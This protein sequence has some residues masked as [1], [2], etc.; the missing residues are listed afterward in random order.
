MGVKQ[1][2]LGLYGYIVVKIIGIKFQVDVFVAFYVRFSTP[3]QMLN[4]SYVLNWWLICVFLFEGYMMTRSLIII[5]ARF[6]NYI[7]QTSYNT[8]FYN[9]LTGTCGNPK[10]IKL[11]THISFTLNVNILYNT[12]HNKPDPINCK[13]LAWHFKK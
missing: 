11:K 13:S 3:S 10:K 1:F 7:A 5:I 2:N 12:A 9:L 8:L 6:N 4:A